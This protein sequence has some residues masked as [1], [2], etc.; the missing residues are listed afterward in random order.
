MNYGVFIQTNPKQ[1]VGAK[2]A[3]Y[4]IRRYSQHNDQF[5]IHIINSRD[6]PYFAAREGQ[7]YTRDKLKR[8]WLNNDLQSFTLTRF[9]PPALMGYQGR[10]LV[11]DPD[12]FAAVDIWDLL[13]MDM[14]DKAILCRL[15]SGLK[16]MAYKAYASSVMLLD[17]AKLKHWQVE[18]Q[19][20]AMFDEDYDY[21]P[22]IHLHNEDPSTIGLFDH[23]WNDL[24][25]FS[26]HTK[27]LHN[28]RRKT[29]PWKAGLPADWRPADNFRGFPPYAWLMWLRRKLFGEYGLI[30][31]YK[32]H[33][34]PNQQRFFFGLLK[35][36]VQKGIVTEAQLRAEM[37]SNHIRHDALQVLQ[38]VPD[39]LPAPLHPLA[40][41]AYH[42]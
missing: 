22:W 16:G 19:F 41:Q 29:Q 8:V 13:T 3:E 10:A 26:L 35:E 17:C 9:M 42:P 14:G 27:M 18:K 39:L 36:C 15:R 28:T 23:H 7:Q 20:N 24:D 33:P 2:A 31:N 11:I 38:Q 37:Q 40:T 30:G 5:S 32:L 1:W 25:T 12:V 4:A 6:Y 34:D 21:L